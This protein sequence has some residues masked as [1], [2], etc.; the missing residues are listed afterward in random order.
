MTNN[1][2]I[3]NGYW[4]YTGSRGCNMMI[5][6]NMD[7]GTAN[8]SIFNST[9]TNSSDAAICINEI[10]NI[11]A[12]YNNVERTAVNTCIRL[13]NVTY[14][15]VSY[16]KCVFATRGVTIQTSVNITAEFNEIVR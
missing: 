3:E 4:Y 10:M 13:R 14:G 15:E 8:I 7:Y 2:A 1:T 11:K 5:Q 12:M 16:N 6:N 9:L